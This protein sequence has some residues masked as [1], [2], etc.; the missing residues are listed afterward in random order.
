MPW[1]GLPQG[2]DTQH[3]HL[4]QRED[5][6]PEHSAHHVPHGLVHVHRVQHL[7]PHAAQGRH[8]HR[9]SV[10]TGSFRPR[11]APASAP[12]S[13]LGAEA[14]RHAARV[15]TA[16]GPRLDASDPHAQWSLTTLRRTHSCIRQGPQRGRHLHLSS[17]PFPRCADPGY[18]RFCFSKRFLRVIQTDSTVRASHSNGTSES[19]QRAN[20]RASGRR[21]GLNPRPVLLA[22]G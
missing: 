18:R 9:P 3:N 5:V 10:Y 14:K 1:R 19:E 13:E 17:R 4:P 22:L 11:T 7:I 6:L 8:R 16:L 21:P 12:R 15:R 20:M 2:M